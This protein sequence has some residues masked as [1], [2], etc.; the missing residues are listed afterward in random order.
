MESLELTRTFHT[1]PERLWHAL[2]DPVALAAWFWP[3]LDNTVEVDLR[4]GGRYRITGPRAGIALAGEYLV[5]D[6]PERLVFTW[7]WEGEDELSRVTVELRPAGART[8]LSLVHDR[9]SDDATRDRFAA[10][11]RDCLDRLPG[12]LDT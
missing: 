12:W 3:Q 11:W 1:T 9:I 6:P 7:R 2:T 4:V 10:G 5:V 8:G